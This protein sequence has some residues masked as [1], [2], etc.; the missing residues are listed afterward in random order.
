MSQKRHSVQA[1]LR[2]SKK[3]SRKFLRAA[4]KQLI[5][6]LRT[7]FR[8]TRNRE[9]SN[10]GFILPTVAMV[11]I[12]V[13]LLT[14]AIMFR[15]FD[16]AKNASNV[17]VNEA[18]IN[19]ATPA[20]DRA[21]AKINKLFEDKRL[22]RATPADSVLYET[23]ANNI[24][25]YTFGDETKLRL[26][27]GANESLTAWRFP[28]DTDNNG[29][30]DSYTLYGIY[31]RNPPL[32]GNQYTRSRN[33]L[34]SRT[35]PM[36]SNNG[37]AGCED[38]F[39]TSATLVGING[40]FKFGS[41][42]KK[43]FFV[44]TATVPITTTTTIPTATS[45][46]YE[47]FKGN[48]GFSAVEY[49]QDR[50]QLPVINNAV[51]YEDD[52][53]LTP[54]ADFKLNGRVFTNSNLLVGSDGATI[55]LYQISSKDSCFYEPDNA[56]VI[57]GGN[58]GIGRFIST[59][60]LNNGAVVHLFNGTGDV[61]TSQIKDHKTVTD[62]PS[63]ITYN[64]LAYVQRIN[65]LVEAQIANNENTDPTEVKEGIQKTKD[66]LGLDSY[67][68]EEEARFRTE[69]LQLYFQ[70][71]TRRVPY[72]EVAFGGNA[73]GTYATT[74]PLTGSGDTLRP[75]NTWSFPNNPVNGKVGTG[76]TGL[77]LRPNTSTKLYPSATE[78][79][80]LQTT[81]GGKEQFLGDR[82]AVGN[83][84]PQ[85]WI[86]GGVFV[87]PNAADTQSISGINWDNP[88]TP[89]VPR[90]R[91][92]LVETLAD[93]GSTD[94]D[95]IW[96]QAAATVPDNPQ[97]PIGGL[98]VITGA[99]IYLPEGYTTTG[100]NDGTDTTY[101]VAKTGTINIWSDMMPVASSTATSPS[102]T[103]DPNIIL[104]NAL[105]PYLRMRATAVYHYKSTGYN[106]DTPIPIACVSSYYDPTSENLA[107]N[108]SG[109]ADVSP[110]DRL[111]TQPYNTT[112]NTNN[113]NSHNGIVYGA[114]NKAV[115]DYQDVLDYQA[116]L[117]YP[118]GRWVNEPLQTALAKTAANRTIAEQ[119]AID[120][121][122][123]ALQIFDGSIPAPF[124]A[125]TNSSRCNSRSSISRC[126][127][128]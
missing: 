57:V 99:G 33:P 68:T 77:T 73:L 11:S 22:P 88:T 82:I 30:F 24:N 126:E 117:K 104:P 63:L 64:S 62:N 95:G 69:Q 49:Q 128:G 35:Q 4:K 78:P 31:L 66:D 111:T 122:I 106:E 1:M 6:L 26:V 107:R 54:G 86:K 93:V 94:R 103:V 120:A 124:Y 116:Q 89:T 75:I 41:R 8:T 113:G 56:K 45:T 17:R 90:T 97:D 119:S 28:V 23:L 80:R 40:W 59:S 79:T 84:L 61:S 7:T 58:I 65:R 39:G 42:L 53:E 114:P 32:S 123:C 100:K 105:T 50:V 20:I 18:V 87:G 10:A 3:N 38:T 91:R 121:E 127:T 43:A 76:Y 92:S 46:N 83:N 109:L 72:R 44:Y 70:K 125:L 55:T 2:I 115:S 60:D 21:R 27:S 51:L 29:R 15:S 101:A 5:H 9:T 34:E 13:V 110:V 98:R 85:L 19:A 14:V 71:R 81:Y 52:L 108:K 74:T 67:T 96:E 36:A 47:V 16:R 48:K 112:I 37:G 118:N 102:S 12:V 25:E